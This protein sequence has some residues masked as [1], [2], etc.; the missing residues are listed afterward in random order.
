MKI[1]T[2]AVHS[3]RGVD[4]QTGAVTPPIHM[5]TTFQRDEDGA[6]P[7]GYVYGRSGNPTREL[8]EDCVRELESAAAAAAFSSCFH[9]LSRCFIHFAMRR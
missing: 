2:V 7:R 4:E 8:L 3:G 6:Y 1:E 9:A 5:A